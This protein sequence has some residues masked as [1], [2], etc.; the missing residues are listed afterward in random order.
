MARCTRFGRYH[1]NQPA[2]LQLTPAALERHLQGMTEKL[3]SGV[4][5]KVREASQKSAAR[6]LVGDNGSPSIEAKPG[7]LLGV[8]GTLPQVEWQR[9][10]AFLAQRTLAIGDWRGQLSTARVV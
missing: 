1:G 2:V 10:Q 5:G 9:V 6:I 7:G 8:D 3:R 4:H